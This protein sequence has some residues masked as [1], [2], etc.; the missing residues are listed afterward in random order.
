MADP[1]AGA[2]R[3]GGAGRPSPPQRGQSCR[4]AS[5]SRSC[6]SPSPATCSWRSSRW[7]YR[8]SNGPCGEPWGISAPRHRRH[9][10]A[11]RRPHHHPRPDLAGGLRL[12]HPAAQGVRRLHAR[13]RGGDPGR[14]HVPRPVL[15]LRLLRGGAGPDVLHHRDLGLGA[16]PLCRHQVLPLHGLRVG[17][18]AGGDHRHGGAPR[19]PVRGSQL[20]PRGPDEPR[21]RAHRGGAPVLR[22]G[23]GVRHQGAGVPAPRGCPT[24]TS[25]PPPPVRCSWPA[26]C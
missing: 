13:A 16:A 10:D 18:A 2:R 20:R 11:A 12:H 14:V 15:L 7:R 17:P 4:W 9:L 21:L 5:P 24:P 25:R 6:R 3:R 1:V 8:S 23:A 26:S 22:P 19:L